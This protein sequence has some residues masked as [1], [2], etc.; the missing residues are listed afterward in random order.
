LLKEE[1]GRLARR[2]ASESRSEQQSQH[3]HGLDSEA[4]SPSPAQSANFPTAADA[5]PAPPDLRPYQQQDLDEIRVAFSSG[6]RAVLYVAPTSSGKTVLFTSLVDGAMRKGKRC[7]ITAHRIEIVEQVSTALAGLG[8]PHGVIAPGFPETPE[9]VQVAS[10]ASLVRRIDRH[11]H[12][13]LIVVDESHHAIAGTWRRVIE[14]MP[15]AKVLGVTATPERLDGRGLG[16]VFGTMVMGPTV[17]ELIEGGY[18]SRFTCFAPTTPD[19]CGIST[20]AGDYAV[21]EL[22]GI[23]ARPVV[24]GS[25]VSSYEKLCLGKRAIVYGVDRRHSMM[26]AKRFTERSHKA[27]HLD[28]DT[29]KEERRALIKA[30]ETGELEII[31]NCGIIS[32]GL[33]V[34]AVEAVLLARPTQSLALFL[35][36]VGRALRPAPGKDRALILDC[37]GNLYRHGMPDADRQWSLGG[38][39]RRQREPGEM[40]RLRRCEHCEAIN[41]PK[42]PTCSAC[43]ADLRPTAQEQRE[44][45]AELR[46]VEHLRRIEALRSMSYG[47][48][49]QW[50]GSDETKLHQV[51]AARGYRRGWVFY[52]L[53]ELRGGQ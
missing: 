48:A 45:E 25:A 8:V 41:P 10:I 38:K 5:R 46:R 43:G 51:A 11:D 4:A 1:T 26:L 30:L 39:P 36:Q 44:I 7:I 27:A 28:G 53:Q 15:G 29:P 3:R 6:A 42:A 34:P 49:L 2:P 52:R 17:A 35:Q 9:P 12:Y 19:L 24:V 21:D 37:A 31:T 16:D 22:A 14:A 20:R 50:A 23:M 13:D 40:P 18:L 47:K 33:D 32:E